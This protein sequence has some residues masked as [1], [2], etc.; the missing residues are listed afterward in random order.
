M[1]YPQSKLLVVISSRNMYQIDTPRRLRLHP[2]VVMKVLQRTQHMWFIL[3]GELA[4]KQL[5]SFSYFDTLFPRILPAK[6]FPYHFL[7]S[8]IN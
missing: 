2:G 4:L 5:L 3:R 7:I 1:F 6:S 8:A